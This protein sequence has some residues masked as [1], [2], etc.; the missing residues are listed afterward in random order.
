MSWLNLFKK[1]PD[2]RKYWCVCLYSNENPRFVNFVMHEDKEHLLDH[3]YFC[4]AKLCLSPYEGS[5]FDLGKHYSFYHKYRA[6]IIPEETEED[7]IRHGKKY[8]GETMYSFPKLRNLQE[9]ELDDEYHFDYWYYKMNVKKYGNNRGMRILSDC[10]W[11]AENAAKEK[12]FNSTIIYKDYLKEFGEFKENPITRQEYKEK[13]EAREQEAREIRN[14][15][16]E[17][18]LKNALSQLTGISMA[19]LKYNN[20]LMD[21]AY[22]VYDKRTPEKQNK[23]SWE[24]INNLFIN[25]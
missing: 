21:M 3:I 20:S 15:Q 22:F 5:H 4:L 11:S 1:E 23:I 18:K 13:A 12:A 6:C 25:I 10:D 2:N 19:F 24:K 17:L 14:K 16:Y 8:A 9:I 7:C